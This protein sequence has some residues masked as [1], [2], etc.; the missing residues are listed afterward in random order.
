MEADIV[1]STNEIRLLKACINNLLSIQTLP[2]IW[3][4]GRP[5]QIVGT[6]LDML[7]ALLELDFAYAQR[8]DS[9]GEG[10]FETVRVAHD[11]SLMIQ[12]QD[13]GRVLSPWL[14]DVPRTLPLLVPNP[15]GD[16]A[17]SI[18]SLGLG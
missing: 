18:A 10:P 8:K 16:G 13:I 4:G 3:D 15:I 11:R 9:T 7:Q 17:V 1:Q 5:S 12:P 2:A 14:G 6:L